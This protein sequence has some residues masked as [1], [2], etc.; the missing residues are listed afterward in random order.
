MVGG[1]VIPKKCEFKDVPRVPVKTGRVE[2]E[3]MFLD[4]L[5]NH[6]IYVSQ[7]IAIRNQ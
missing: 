1:V 3:L 6:T 5:I 4:I 7:E 2:D